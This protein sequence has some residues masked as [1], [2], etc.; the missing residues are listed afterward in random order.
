M[1]RL[2]AMVFTGI[3]PSETVTNAIYASDVIEGRFLTS[4]DGYV[5]L[6][7]KEYAELNNLTLGSTVTY[8]ADFEVVGIIEVTATNIMKSHIYVNLPVVQEVLPEKPVGLVNMGLIRTTSPD[9]VTQTAAALEELWPDSSTLTGLDLAEKAVGVIQITEN[10]AWSISL[11]LIV[12]SIFFVVKSQVGNV[13]ERTREIGILKAIG[14][15]NKN[16]VNQ[17]VV[18]STVQGVI[19]GVVGVSLGYV[20]AYYVLSTIGG[21]M[22]GALKFVSID[23]ILLG[24]GFAVATLSAVVAGLFA[25]W[26]AARLAPVEALRTT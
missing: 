2:R 19:G 24:V 5:A 12:V 18:E 21:G 13:A 1:H 16:I 6:V 15:S 3:D 25:S 4:D 11:A 26:R 20:F 17:I 22:G 23:P 7:D 8:G 14:W 10:T 9:K